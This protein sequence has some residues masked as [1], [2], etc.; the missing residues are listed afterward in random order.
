[1]MSPNLISIGSMV[2]DKNTEMWKA[3]RQD[4][5]GGA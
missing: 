4:D 2:C 5:E 3:N 1:M